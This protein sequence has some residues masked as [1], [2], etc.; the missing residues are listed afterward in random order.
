M[1]AP[2]I[3]LTYATRL[4]AHV[5]LSKPEHRWY[6]LEVVKATSL[7]SGT[8]YPILS[9]MER[10]GWLTSAP[11]ELPAGVRMG[12]PPRRYYTLTPNFPN[13]GF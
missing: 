1:V 5:L 6:G 8:V 13:T 9:R 4:V 12:R 7:P 11:E 2:R 3:R 10:H